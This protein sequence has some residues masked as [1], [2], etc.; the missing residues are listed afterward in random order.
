MT[1]IRTVRG[2]LPGLE[3]E[4]DIYVL[5]GDTHISKWVEEARRLDHDQSTLP[6]IGK[7]IGPESVV[8][9]LGA[10]IG[11]H[12][13]FYASKT[14]RVVCFEAMWDAFDCLRKNTAHYSNVECWFGAIGDGSLCE[15][16]DV[17]EMNKGARWVAPSASGLRSDTIDDSLLQMPP[18]TLIKLDI[19]GWEV[20]ALRGAARTIR[21]HHP[22]IV[23]EVN[24]DA[25]V[26]AGTSP[27]ELHALLLSY[28]YEMTDLFTGEGWFPEDHRLQ[29]DVVC[30]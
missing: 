19:E 14:K 15:D 12:T 1:A 28:G 3:G 11:D 6:A 20:R 2:T 18:P 5:E 24:R 25:L 21:E 22:I 26:R 9:D 4:R 10:F 29:F 27:E 17:V 7:L 13:A 23:C 30:R 8:Y 16:V